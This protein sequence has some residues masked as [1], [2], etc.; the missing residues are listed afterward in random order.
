[1]ALHVGSHP[2]VV[3]VREGDRVRVEVP[4]VASVSDFL[5]LIGLAAVVLAALAAGGA[6]LAR[7]EW[8]D[9]QDLGAAIALMPATPWPTVALMGAL[10]LAWVLAA[11]LFLRVPAEML[12]GR[13]VVE[14]DLERVRLTRTIGPIEAEREIPVSRIVA[15]REVEP[16]GSWRLRL[17]GYRPMWSGRHGRLELELE[18]GRRVRFGTIDAG[19]NLRILRGAVNRALSEALES[20]RGPEGRQ[21]RGET[22]EPAVQ[23]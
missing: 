12:L 22:L 23:P 3:V 19:T 21:T 14:I 8:I 20:S 1:M 18:G 11:G 2:E 15:L 6:A 9:V 4:T 13:E 7:L 5:T 10:L 16:P 17:M